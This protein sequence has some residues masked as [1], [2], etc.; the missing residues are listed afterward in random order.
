[1]TC[2]LKRQI[3][4]YISSDTSYTLEYFQLE[5]NYKVYLAQL[6]GSLRAGQKLKHVVK[7]IVQCLLNTDRHGV[8]TTPRNPVPLFDHPLGREMLPH[9]QSK[10]PLTWSSFELFPCILSLDL[11]EEEI[12]TSFPISHLQEAVES[13]EVTTHPHFFTRLGKPKALSCSFHISEVIYI[14]LLNFCSFFQNVFKTLNFH[15]LDKWSRWR[16]TF[17]KNRQIV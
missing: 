5:G 9:V 13:S 1:M 2:N 6:P 17:K 8:L 14:M 16:C 15:S 3:N 7:G 10:P 12:S 11:R 4:Y